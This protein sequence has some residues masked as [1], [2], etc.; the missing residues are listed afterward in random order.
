VGDRHAL[1]F[2]IGLFARFLETYAEGRRGLG[3]ALALLGRAPVD[4]L[5]GKGVVHRWFEPFDAVLHVDGVR[6]P[7]DRWTNVSAGGIPDLGF[8]LRPYTR[9]FERRGHFHVIAHA[10]SPLGA[11]AE[12]PR[13]RMGLGMKDVVQSVAQRVVIETAR[14]MIHALDGDVFEA[15]TRFEVRAGPLVRFLVPW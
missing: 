6:W 3:A 2:G 7:Q 12:L 1:L 15:Q 11:L 14:P 8:G 9:A 5:R 13:L 4:A 10:L